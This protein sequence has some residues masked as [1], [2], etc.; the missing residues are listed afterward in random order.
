MSAQQGSIVGLGTVRAN[1]AQ[2][3]LICLPKSIMLVIIRL[4]WHWINS[5]SFSLL[6]FIIYFILLLTLFIFSTYYM[7]FYN[8]PHS[9]HSVKIDCSGP[10]EQ[11]NNSRGTFRV[12]ELWYEM[13]H[14]YKVKDVTKVNHLVQFTF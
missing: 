12:C 7:I 13:N 11:E 10:F 1:S 4:I 3:S 9:S 5:M 8:Q 6:Y 2:Y 14:K